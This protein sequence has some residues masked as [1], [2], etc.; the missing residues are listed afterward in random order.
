MN[1]KTYR[2]TVEIDFTKIGYRDTLVKAQSAEHAWELAALTP[3]AYDWSDAR[4]PGEGS[5]NDERIVDV[6]EEEGE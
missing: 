4:F 5:V 6:T 3:W 2:V 1:T